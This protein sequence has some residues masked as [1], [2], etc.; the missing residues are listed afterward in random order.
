MRPVLPE[1]RIHPAALSAVEQNHRSI[2]DEVSAAVDRDA[3]VVVGMAQNP[4]VKRARKALKDAGVS[5]T[6]LEYGSYLSD[7]RKRN[8]LKMWTGW[9]TFPMVFAGGFLIG[10]ASDTEA[11]LANGDLQRIAASRSLVG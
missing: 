9:P 11:L 1:S 5:F 2:V 3:V 10:G 7:W 4:V 8:A 6:Y